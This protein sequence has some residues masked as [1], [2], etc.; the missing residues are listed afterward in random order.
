MQNASELEIHFTTAYIMKH[1]ILV[2]PGPSDP[3]YMALSLFFLIRDLVPEYGNC[4][5]CRNLGTISTN[6]TMSLGSTQPLTEMSTMNLPG[7][8]G[9]RRVRLTTSPQSMSGLSKKYGSL[10][11]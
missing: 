11:V 6:Y 9:G 1:E 3:I 5:V 2:G 4:S 10:D 8:N 7:V